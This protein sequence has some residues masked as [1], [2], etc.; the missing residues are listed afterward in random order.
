MA[1][2]QLLTVAEVAPDLQVT[3][4]TIRNWIER[5]VLAAARIGRG[6]RI[7]REDIHELLARADARAGSVRDPPRCV[8]ADDH[9]L[10]RRRSADARVRCSEE[11]GFS[12]L[13]SCS[14]FRLE[15]PARSCGGRSD[16]EHERFDDDPT[17]SR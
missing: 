3:P 6:Y 1:D 2:S 12:G 8:D 10:S 7:R 16:S 17:R 9:R 15:P 13:R 5:G 11:G 4:Q 14:S